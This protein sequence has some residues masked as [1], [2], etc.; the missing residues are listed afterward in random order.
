M[1]SKIEKLAEKCWSH[2]INGTLIDGHLHFDY[3][4]FADLLIGECATELSKVPGGYDSSVFYK[5]YTLLKEHF[6][7]KDKKS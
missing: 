3:N 6:E 2:H 4:K 1:K 7:I 5:N